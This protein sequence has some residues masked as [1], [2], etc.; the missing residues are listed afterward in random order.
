MEFRIIL[1]SNSRKCKCGKYTP[2]IWRNLNGIKGRRGLSEGCHDSGTKRKTNERG[3]LSTA[4]LDTIDTLGEVTCPAEETEKRSETGQTIYSVICMSSVL[5]ILP[6][7]NIPP[8]TSVKIRQMTASTKY[9]ML[10]SL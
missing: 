3:L 1:N 5:P 4:E 7:R 8:N 6:E 2:T 9:N 10:P